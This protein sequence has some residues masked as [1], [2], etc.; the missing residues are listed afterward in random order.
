MNNDNGNEQASVIEKAR[1]VLMHGLTADPILAA[2]P[3][4]TNIAEGI[5][6]RWSSHRI[7][8]GQWYRKTPFW[9]HRCRPVK[10]R[11]RGVCEQCHYF[12]ATQVNHIDYAT[13]FRESPDDLEHLCVPCHEAYTGTGRRSPTLVAAWITLCTDACQKDRFALFRLRNTLENLQAMPN[14]RLLEVSHFLMFH[15]AQN[16]EHEASH[17]SSRDSMLWFDIWLGK[18]GQF[19]GTKNLREPDIRWSLPI[20]EICERFECPPQN[21]RVCW[22]C[23]RDWEIGLLEM[24]ARKL[25]ETYTEES[26]RTTMSDWPSKTLENPFLPGIEDLR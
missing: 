19:L 13:W 6:N 4:P 14:I 24:R 2:F 15:F 9:E 11:S 20:A 7:A 16:E 10:I 5:L 1:A 18:M 21:R 25:R 8:A 26:L 23:A 12:R 22:R 17:A 3:I